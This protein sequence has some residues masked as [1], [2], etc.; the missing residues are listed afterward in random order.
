MTKFLIS[1]RDADANIAHAVVEGDRMES[2]IEQFAE[3]NEWYV[4]FDNSDGNYIDGCFGVPAGVPSD[5]S[6]V[7]IRDHV[8]IAHAILGDDEDSL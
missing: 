2:A 8:F 4:R 6:F 7:I 1:Y 5:G 3:R